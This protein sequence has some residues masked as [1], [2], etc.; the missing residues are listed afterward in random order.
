M[1]YPGREWGL[2]FIY[3]NWVYKTRLGT[4]S[5]YIECIEYYCFGFC[6]AFSCSLLCV[7]LSPRLLRFTIK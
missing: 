6:V 2:L 7:P 1:E 5:N 4:I 3:M